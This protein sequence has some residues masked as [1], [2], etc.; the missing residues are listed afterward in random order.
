M[1]KIQSLVHAE[2]AYDQLIKNYRDLCEAVHMVRK[3]VQITFGNGL[4]P[5]RERSDTPVHDCEMIARAIYAAGEL[6]K[7]PTP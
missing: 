3:A 6:K 4:L 1:E 2:K 7:P 5:D